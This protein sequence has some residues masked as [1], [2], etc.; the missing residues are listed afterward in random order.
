PSQVPDGGAC[1]DD[2]Q[3]GEVARYCSF[4][5]GCPGSCAAKAGRDQVCSGRG[6]PTLECADPYVCT[7]GFDLSAPCQCEQPAAHGAAC[8]GPSNTPCAFS[9]H[10][11][12]GSARTTGTCWSFDEYFART[13]GQSCGS[14]VGFCAGGLFCVVESSGQFCRNAGSVGA[15]A[16]CTEAF[17]SQCPND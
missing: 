12:G 4:A 3:C 5:S 8:A 14:S 9:L 7:G 15:F 2:L 11:V 10:C 1:T 17:P 6:L 16:S 13:S